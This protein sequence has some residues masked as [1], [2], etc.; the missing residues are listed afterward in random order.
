MLVRAAR[1]HKQR[2]HALGGRRAASAG[3]EVVQEAHA[4]LLKRHRGS[5]ARSASA[6]AEQARN[7]AAHPTR[8]QT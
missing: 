3:A 8:T 4:A 2:V 5:P 1:R 7:D 6:A